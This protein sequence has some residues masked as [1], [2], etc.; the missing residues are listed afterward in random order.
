MTEFC[1]MIVPVTSA[2][3][4]DEPAVR[5]RNGTENQNDPFASTGQNRDRSDLSYN[6]HPSFFN[7]LN[8]GTTTASPLETPTAQPSASASHEAMAASNGIPDKPLPMRKTR[9]AAADLTSRKL[10]S[11]ITR[12]NNAETKRSAVPPPEPSAPPAPARRSTR[13]NTLKFASKIGTTDKEARSAKERE[14]EVKKRA[15]SAR[16]RNAATG[17]DKEKDK[18]SED[19]NVSEDLA[20]SASKN[21]GELR[22]ATLQASP[23]G[24][25]K[26]KAAS[27][28]SLTRVTKKQMPDAAKTPV[29]SAPTKPQVTIDQP[30]QDAQVFLLEMYRKIGTGYFCL[31]RY[32]CT[33]A[34]QA[35][36]SLPMGQR[37][38]PRIQ[39]LMGRAYYEMANYN[40]VCDDRS[41]IVE[42]RIC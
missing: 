40:E 8:E 15:V 27:D 34:L 10:T 11:R 37:E 26:R 16:I 42:T 9:A 30:K 41:D 29:I 19:I 31:T 14:R 21:D 38:T 28:T 5:M 20:P 13:L 18:A 35:F 22:A 7:R 33:D 3:T 12:D 17:K 36:S 25:L 23:A 2:A 24:V 6:N 32:N 4:A 1:K 39:C